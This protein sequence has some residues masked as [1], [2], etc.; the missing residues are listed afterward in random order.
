MLADLCVKIKEWQQWLLRRK[1]WKISLDETAEARERVSGTGRDGGDYRQ[2]LVCFHRNGSA[3]T[4]GDS[5]IKGREGKKI[6]KEEKAKRKIK[7][8]EI[9]YHFAVD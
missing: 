6:G 2:F 5:L 4:A 3:I 1:G 7:P 9:C 8:R